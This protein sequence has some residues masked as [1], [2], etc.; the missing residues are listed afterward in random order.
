MEP[1]LGPF[2]VTVPG[3]FWLLRELFPTPHSFH[4]DYCSTYKISNF[5]W[6]GAGKTLK[7]DLG[8]QSTPTLDFT[9][10][11]HILLPPQSVRPLVR[12]LCVQLPYLVF[13]ICLLQAK[14]PVV[15]VN[16]F[17]IRSRFAPLSTFSL[18][19]CFF[20]FCMPVLVIL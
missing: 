7:G 13:G 16:T 17:A 20:F 18:A 15:Y 11:L 4:D 6:V 5:C 3:S 12:Q 2:G 14:G 19:S 8:K 1:S 9:R 10:L